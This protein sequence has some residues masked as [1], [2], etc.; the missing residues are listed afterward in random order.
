MTAAR[1][2]VGPCKRQLD[3]LAFDIIFSRYGDLLDDWCMAC[4]RNTLGCQVGELR[5][6]TQRRREI[7]AI[8]RRALEVA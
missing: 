4:R 3:D 1:T 2:C 5:N 7:L 6:M 8:R